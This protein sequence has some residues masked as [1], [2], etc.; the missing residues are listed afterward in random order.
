[1]N[2]KKAKKLRKLLREIDKA[3]PDEARKAVGYNEDVK[4]RKMH[5]FEV[6]NPTTGAKESKPYPIAPGMVTV[7]KGTNRGRYLYLKKGLS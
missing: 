6:V 7:D 4:K 5:N 2:A 3:S 1:M